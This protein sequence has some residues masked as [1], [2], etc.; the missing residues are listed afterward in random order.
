MNSGLTPGGQSLSKRETVFSLLVDP[1]NKE[2]KDPETVDLNAP[3]VAWYKQKVGKK[4]QNTVYWGRYQSCSKERIQLLSDTIERHHLFQY[5]PSL[6]Y[7]ESCQDGNWRNHR[8]KS[9]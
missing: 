1:M 2:N 7:P 4:H 5:A 9:I 3:R 8:R 6:V